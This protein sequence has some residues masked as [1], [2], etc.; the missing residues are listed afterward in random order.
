METQI[1]KNH[2]T[3]FYDESNN[4]RSLILSGDE[5]NIDNDPNQDSSPIFVLGGI[6]YKGNELDVGINF[7]ELKTKLKRE[8]LKHTSP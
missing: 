7:N 3:L 6:A 8:R 4:I 5:Y 2:D 1:T